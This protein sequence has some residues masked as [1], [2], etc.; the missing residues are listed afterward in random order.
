[1]PRLLFRNHAKGSNWIDLKCCSTHVFVSLQTIRRQ[2]Q[3]V[4]LRKVRMQLKDT[5][6]RRQV[7]LTIV[8]TKNSKLSQK[9]NG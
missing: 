2:L 3:T 1:M 6:L 5:V 4:G 8:A 9:N 7:P